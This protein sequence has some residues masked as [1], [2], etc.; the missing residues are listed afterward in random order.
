MQRLSIIGPEPGDGSY[1]SVTDV[2]CGC[3]GAQA[4]PLWSAEDAVNDFPLYQV[5]QKRYVVRS[6]EKLDQPS[7]RG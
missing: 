7:A 4:F 2:P 5:P 3:D 6:L 1:R